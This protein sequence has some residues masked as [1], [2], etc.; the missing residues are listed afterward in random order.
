MSQTPDYQMAHQIKFK[1]IPLRG[2]AETIILVVM[3]VDTLTTVA[4]ANMAMDV[5]VMVTLT[6]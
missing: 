3:V 6:I 4:M 5:V 1:I 2:V